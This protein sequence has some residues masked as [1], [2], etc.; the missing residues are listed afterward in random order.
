MMDVSEELISATSFKKSRNKNSS[1]QDISKLS[2]DVSSFISF[3]FVFLNKNCKTHLRLVFIPVLIVV[4][5]CFIAHY[6][7]T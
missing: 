7:C 1:P 5:T 3:S 2:K 6:S 4:I